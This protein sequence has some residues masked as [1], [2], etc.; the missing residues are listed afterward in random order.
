MDLLYNY[1]Y[2]ISAIV[3]TTVIVIVFL[4][5]MVPL[6]R[7]GKYFLQLL[8]WSMITS[9]FSIVSIVATARTN[10]IP[11]WAAY[12]S[13]LGHSFMRNGMSVVF[14]QYIDSK[15]KIPKVKQTIVVFTTSIYCI[16]A[17][18]M[19][20]SPWT[21]VIVHI[22]ELN[23]YTQGTMPEVLFAIPIVMFTLEIIFIIAGKKMFSWQQFAQLIF[24]AMLMTVST[25]ML[26]IYPTILLFDFVISITLLCLYVSF[27]NPA[28]YTY[29]DTRFLNYRAFMQTIKR[30]DFDGQ[31]DKHEIW[32]IQDSEDSELK[33]QHGS[34][35]ISNLDHMESF[36]LHNIFGNRFFIFSKD[37]FAVL[38]NKK[39]TSSK[40]AALKA[41]KEL[42]PNFDHEAILINDNHQ[43]IKEIEKII[44]YRMAYVSEKYK[45]M[46]SDDFVRAIEKKH[47]E[48]QK[49]I[50]SIKRA[51]YNDSFK[52][53]YQPIY[54]NK[55]KRFRS[56]EAL[57]RCIDEEHGFIDPESL[58]TIAE[59]YGYI[60][61]ITDIVYERVCKFISENNIKQYGVDYIEINMS[62][63]NCKQENLVEKL[64]KI[65]KKYNVPTE[66]INLE[67]TETADIHNNETINNMLSA[68]NSS[69]ISLSIDDY[70]SGF[71][72]PNYLIKIPVSIVKI[73]KEILWS[74]MSDESAMHILK[75]TIGMIT[76]LSK[77]IVIEGVE[78]RQMVETLNSINNE[79]HFQG[80][81]YSKPVPEAE[82]INFLQQYSNPEKES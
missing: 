15:C 25:V 80:Y 16:L 59:K 49:I 5:K 60:D 23:E 68:M 63:E 73:D 27:E 46:S 44:D 78:N 36:K 56:A 12:I 40:R 34:I 14:L 3:L 26:N 51:I 31:L 9:M 41:I 69:G 35:Y 57:I 76:G 11:K 75:S 81:Y 37:I 54:D 43:S 39:D 24:L 66:M 33:R 32:L 2:N 20:T 8:I 82:F 13:I 67:I 21:R 29:K 52:V 79:M 42:H 77:K 61:Q 48:I 53:Y 55:A 30:L 7:S 22:N 1:Q 45:N 19:I 17:V 38:I 65:R 74:A 6:D 47:D 4:S 64:A 18:V 71:A 28:Y 58:I 62:P 10:E 70:G 50:D 72:S